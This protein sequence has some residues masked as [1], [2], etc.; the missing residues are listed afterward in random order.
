MVDVIV[1]E[2]DSHRRNLFYVRRLDKL[3]AEYEQHRVFTRNR[4]VVSILCFY[5]TNLTHS[6]VNHYS[7][8]YRHGGQ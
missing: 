7:V 5:F 8:L 6:N 4:I 3:K 2:Q 1:I